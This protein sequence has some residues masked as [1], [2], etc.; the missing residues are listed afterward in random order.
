[1]LNVFDY[2]IVVLY[3]AGTVALGLFIG[4]RLK[5]GRDFFLA[6]RS[7]PWW[8]IGVSLV[9]TDIGAT[10]IIGVGG[11]AYRYG[12]AVANFEWIG[13]VPAMIVGAFIFIPYFWRLG[14][15]TIPEFMERRYNVAVRG[16]VAFCW[17]L[18]MASN[19]GILLYASA[20]MVGELFGWDM[21]ASILGIAAL[22]G[23]Y[24]CAGGLAAVIYTDVVQGVVM[25]GGCLLVL[26]LGLVE[27]GGVGELKEALRR[28]EAAATDSAVTVAVGVEDPSG[29]AISDPNGT[30]AHARVIL[31][32]DTTTPFPWP[33]IFFGLALILSPAYWIGNQAI[34]QRSLGARS[35]FDA[36]AAYVWGAL[37]KTIVPLVVA[38]PGLIA[39]AR[40]PDL[41]DQVKAIPTLVANLL[42]PGLR[43]V[44]LAA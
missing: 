22:A 26:V 31:P 30:P 21:T 23:L 41:A 44:F 40:N 15:Y 43:G 10:D 37:L 32:V 14:V 3:I 20:K 4:R 13:C 35:E 42:P 27:I 11:Q 7:M 17:L 2:V 29:G 38:V 16:A 8:A 36:R 24:T 1:M 19:V 9:A 18:F 6:G 33:G 28:A 25:I 39:F 34:V 5:T 12:L